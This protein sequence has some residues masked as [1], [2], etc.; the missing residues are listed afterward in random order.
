MFHLFQIDPLCIF[1]I[2][3]TSPRLP[4]EIGPIYFSKRE[5]YDQLSLFD[6]KKELP[7]FET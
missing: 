5:K 4:F 3:Q 7:T 6:H 1:M 2:F